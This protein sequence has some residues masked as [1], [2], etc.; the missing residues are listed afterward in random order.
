MTAICRVLGDKRDYT[1]NVEWDLK[2]YTYNRLENEYAIGLYVGRFCLRNATEN[3]ILISE[4]REES[5]LPRPRQNAK[6]ICIL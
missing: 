3:N 4:I 6:I 1:S 2:N 5:I